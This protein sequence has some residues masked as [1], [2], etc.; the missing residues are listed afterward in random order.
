[1][2]HRTLRNDNH[3][4]RWSIKPICRDQGRHMKRAAAEWHLQLAAALRGRL[5]GGAGRQRH[6]RRQ[7]PLPALQQHKGLHPPRPL[8]V[9]CSVQFHRPTSCRLPCCT[10][11][12]TKQLQINGQPGKQIEAG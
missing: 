3:S 1:M 7:P 5:V 11:Q 6:R 10:N 12:A 9:A 2:C 4:L 8:R